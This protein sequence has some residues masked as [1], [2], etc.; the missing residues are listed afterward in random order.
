LFSEF[1]VH[2]N[3]NF[4]VEIVSKSINRVMESVEAESY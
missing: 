3:F 2:L 4:M 1:E